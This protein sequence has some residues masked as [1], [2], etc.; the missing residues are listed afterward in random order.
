MEVCVPVCVLWGWQE[1]ILWGC[2]P[3]L[4]RWV[5]HNA[6][7][8]FSSLYAECLSLLPFL[9]PPPWNVHGG[10]GPFPVQPQLYPWLWLW[11]WLSG[12]LN[13]LAQ[14]QGLQLFLAPLPWSHGLPMPSALGVQAFSQLSPLLNSELT[15]GSG[16][17]AGYSLAYRKAA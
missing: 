15:L 11:L 12:P 6:G 5:T 2:Q 1:L 7:R 9:L 10:F 3:S 14:P 13:S 8:N 17:G 16:R 4:E